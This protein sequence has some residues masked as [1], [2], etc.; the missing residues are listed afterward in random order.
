MPELPEVEGFRAFA[1]RHVVGRTIVRAR[2]LDDLMLLGTTRRAFAAGLRGRAVT[3][4]SRRGKL[5]II[6]CSGPAIAVHFGM[7]GRPSMAASKYD[8]LVLEL[9]DGTSFHYA[10]M[11]RLG[12]I[13]LV[14][15]GELS[16]LLW[17]LG[18]DALEAPSSWFRDALARR[19]APIKAVLLNQ[20][21]IAG[22]GNIWADEALFR[23]GVHPSRPANEVD[24]RR[25][26]RALRTLLRRG[27]AD[28]L[29]QTMAP[30]RLKVPRR[31]GE[32]CTRC[33]TPIESRAI[34]GR[35]SYYCV[36]CQ[37]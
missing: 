20:A 30:L 28:N 19:R 14:A 29:A 2:A 12:S 16:D 27:V 8:R 34:G 37:H 5:M 15:P 24:A 3:A 1:E 11:R 7:T 13:R 10:N 21:F 36:H 22:V 25:L 33:G 17:A 18:P 4:V 31:A 35:T 32:P 9:D 6:F 23:A 26:H